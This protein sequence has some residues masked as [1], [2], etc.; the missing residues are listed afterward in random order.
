MKSARPI[1][2]A[3]SLLILLFG[4]FNIISSNVLIL[5]STPNIMEKQNWDVARFLVANS[6]NEAVYMSEKLELIRH[7]VTLP[8]SIHI[9]ESFKVMLDVEFDRL[10]ITFR[11]QY[12]D[13]DLNIVITSKSKIINGKEEP[14]DSVT[15]S[16]I[17]DIITGFNEK[18]SLKAVGL[19]YEPI[20]NN[21]PSHDENIPPF[22]SRYEWQFAPISTP[23]SY[24]AK[25]KTENTEQIIRDP[26]TN[27][28]IKYA[29]SDVNTLEFPIKIHR[30]I[31]SILPSWGAFCLGI[32]TIV[33]M[34]IFRPKN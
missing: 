25:I 24:T 11:K 1:L 16:Y 18:Y 17:D 6:Q 27:S 14:I 20:G 19:S 8:S 2:L 5:S 13:S 21:N 7:I 30:T 4:L 15:K 28:E 3:T 10:I 12:S 22:I 31:E 9:Q 26:W 33:L 32:I 34:I 23:A 29:L